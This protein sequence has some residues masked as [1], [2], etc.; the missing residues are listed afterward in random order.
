MM[1]TARLL[2]P[3]LLLLLSACEGLFTGTGEIRQPLTEAEDGSFAPVRLALSPEMNPLAVNFHGETVPS[4]LESGRWNDY[5]A[6]LT[7]A[8]ATIASGTFSINNAGAPR[9]E[10]GGAFA[11]TMFYVTVP[12][13]GE[14]KLT[15]APTKPKEIT[16]Q[17]PRV[18]VRKHVQPPVKPAP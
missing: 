7:L 6:T 18:E 11:Q 3:A 10:Q 1:Q 14:Y 12:Q 17:A 4:P 5:R 16:I 9:H 13:A 2:L 15:I 8:G